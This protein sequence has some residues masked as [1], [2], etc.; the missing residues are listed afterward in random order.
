MQSLAPIVR[1][2]VLLAIATAIALCAGGSAAV[3]ADDQNLAFVQE[4]DRIGGLLDK[5]DDLARA[6]DWQSAVERLMEAEELLATGGA[7]TDPTV[8]FVHPSGIDG[9][10]VGVEEAIARRLAR[11]PAEAIAHY[12]ST[13]DPRAADL[14]ARAAEGEDASAFDEVH[15]TYPLSAPGITALERVALAAFE[16]GDLDRVD[17]ALG[18]LERLPAT[19]TDGTDVDVDR[20]AVRRFVAN[21]VRGDLDAARAVARQLE[22]DG[23]APMIRLGKGEARTPS[24]WLAG[25]TTAAAP[26]ARSFTVARKLRSVLG[27]TVELDV[28]LA[29]RYA[30]S[31]LARPLPSLPAFVSDQAYIADNKSLS[32]IDLASGQIA[33]TV[34]RSLE[35]SQPTRLFDVLARPAIVGDLVVFSVDLGVPPERIVAA[36][37]EGEEDAEEEFVLNPRANH[38]LVAVERDGG[39]VVWDTGEDEE[40]GAALAREAIALSAPLVIGDRVFVTATVSKSDLQ[41]HLVAFDL[42]TGKIAFRTFLCSTSPDNYLRIAATASP[43]VQAGGLILCQTNLGLV[44]AIDPDDGHFVWANRYRVYPRRAQSDYIEAGRRFALTEPVVDGDAAYVG[45]RDANWLYALDTATGEVR[46]RFPRDGAR[47]VLGTHGDDLIVAG[48]RVLSIDRRSGALRSRSPELGEG[49]IA[50]SGVIVG[51]RILVP[52]ATGIVEVDARTLAIGGRYWFEDPGAEL[53]HLAVVEGQGRSPRLVSV[54]AGRLHVYEDAASVDAAGGP[55]ADL[56]L[57]EVGV[58]RGNHKSAV[59]R[60][61]KA[62]VGGQLGP[63]QADRAHRLIVEA[64]LRAAEQTGVG[65]ELAELGWACKRVFAN[66]PSPAEHVRARQLFGEAL[67]AAGDGVDAA[68]QFQAILDDARLRGEFIALPTGAVVRASAY[69]RGRLTTVIADFGREAYAEQDRAASELVQD[70]LRTGTK[71]SLEELLRR[72]PVSVNAPRAR[73]LLAQHYEEKGLVSAAT[74]LLEDYLADDA[75]ELGEEAAGVLVRLVEAYEA[76]R[77][78]RAARRVLDELLERF[79]DSRVTHGEG[80]ITV[81]DY[82]RAKLGRAEY[83]HADGDSISSIQLPLDRLWRTSTDLL[84]TDSE[85]VVPLR[86]S[87]RERTLLIRR[88]MDLEA[89]DLASGTF[90]WQRAKVGRV[91]RRRAPG[92]A[93]GRLFLPERRKVAAIDSLAGTIDFA[94]ELAPEA[95]PDDEDGNDEGDVDP[96][97]PFGPG[98]RVG[99]DPVHA[100]GYSEDHVVV[101]TGWNELRGYDASNGEELWRRPFAA[102]L[103]GDV[104]VRGDRAVVATRQP[105][106]VIGVDLATGE[107][108]YTTDF[109]EQDLTSTPVEDAN[110][111]IYLVIA[112]RVV[113]AVEGA[114]GEKRWERELPYF[115]RDVRTVPGGDSVVAVGP[116]VPGQPPFVVLRTED[117]RPFWEGEAPATGRVE[118]VFVGPER[119]YALQSLGTNFTLH[120]HELR[121]GKLLWKWQAP[122]GQAALDLFETPDHLLLPRTDADGSAAVCIVEKRGGGLENVLKVPGRR[123][124]S[125]SVVGGVFVLLTDRGDFGLGKVDKDRTWAEVVDLAAQLE[126]TPDDAELRARLADRYFKLGE[127]DRAVGTL[128]DGILSEQ[129]GLRDYGMLYG[130]LAGM[131][132]EQAENEMMSLEVPRLARPPEIDGEL[133][134]E[135]VRWSHVDLHG[136]TRVALIQ[137]DRGEET[138]VWRG[139]EDL[140]GRVFFGY[141]ER[142]LYFAVDIRDMNL[143]PYDSEAD[144]WVGDCLLIALDPRNDGGYWFARDDTLLSLALTLPR[145]KKKDEDEE[146]EGED[147]NKPKGK[148]FVKRKDDGTGAIY[149]AEIPWSVLASNGAKVPPPARLSGFTFGFNL[150]VT[151]DDGDRDGQGVERG[152]TKYLAITPGILLHKRKDRLWQGFI[153]EHFPRIT[154]K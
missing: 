59:G 46:W 1:A 133:N 12:R 143:R 140:S 120:A 73:L 26:G 60:L 84:G 152:A 30:S 138:A 45:P 5:A 69:A 35:T 112:G 105:A 134:D 15:A 79:P 58:R 117:G 33:W 39:K 153:P 54:A 104:M 47:R 48:D 7:S 29:T 128:D 24:Q 94:I 38:R 111:T 53:G 109:G 42:R 68:R 61:E 57:G 66:R 147:E 70:A 144:T 121:T 90:L 51:D 141:D 118:R 32:L 2:A 81:V 119:L 92:Y 80:D 83:M 21:L 56:R 132:E 85:V 98:P 131:K 44:A 9:V 150:V 43:P 82:V 99:P 67:V 76:M 95:A 27:H 124:H 129:I 71:T 148:Y 137:R 123:L 125:A 74:P 108:A 22:A 3:H 89:R 78:M 146:G 136:P 87:E 91:G 142:A 97:V 113:V 52:T 40:G 34:D 62:L 154:L 8:R 20:I 17:R 149:E 55:F 25:R 6:G 139:D 135:W 110:G 130:Q 63:A 151:D 114:N 41:S 28:T 75:P 122:N 65:G 19:L 106:R 36:P 115:V 37:V 116:S 77:R 102:R 86:R 127:I 93:A 100:V 23:A 126:A 31:G 107:V 145:K 11:L 72:F 4:N 16:A 50:A 14:L 64:S 103:S 13:V 10:F 96:A 49:G 88:G 18:R 101:L